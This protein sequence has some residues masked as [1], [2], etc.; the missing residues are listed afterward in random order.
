[1]SVT[2]VIE[3]VVVLMMENHS[4]DNMLGWLR[5]VGELTGKESNQS[6]EGVVYTTGAY[7]NPPF[8]TN[9]CPEH[10]FD[11]VT[12]QIFGS[13]QDQPADMSGFVRDYETT[14]GSKYP[15]LD[16]G[17]IMGCYAPTAV[18]VI[19]ALSSNF[20]VCTRWFCSVPGPTSPNRIYANCA[21]SAGYVGGAWQTGTLP[22]NWGSLPS[23]FGAL[24]NSKNPKTNAPYTWGVYFEQEQFAVELALGD[25]QKS[26]QCQ[27]CDPRFET[28]FLPQLLKGT[29]PNYCFLTPGLFPDSQHSPSDVRY[30]EC[31]MANVYEMIAN[32]SYWEKTLFII[33]YDEH[34]G[35]YDSVVPPKGVNPD[36]IDS[37]SPPFQFDRLGVR[38]PAI[39]ISP[40]V[41][42]GVDDTQY[43]HSSIAATV[44]KLFG[45]Y[46][47][48]T[49]NNNRINTVKTFEGA[50]R[51]PLRNDVP[52]TLQ[53]PAADYIPLSAPLLRG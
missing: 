28:A 3:N 21:S 32:S 38:V 49:L 9:P 27:Y 30:G 7:P 50:I 40:Y 10:E 19:S 41:Q 6:N 43:E 33:T 51:G 47:S 11:N 16:L 29:L 46:P 35:F 48:T 23:I 44:L 53:R 14:L 34:G 31:I 37:L 4:F 1:M 45:L 42:A 26:P 8:A 24:A 22:Q 17:A 52:K 25:V 2:P 5:G 12:A 39:L 13:G 15:R 20:T 18:P 36:G